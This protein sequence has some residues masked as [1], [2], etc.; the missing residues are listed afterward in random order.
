MNFLQLF[1]SHLIKMLLIMQAIIRFLIFLRS[2]TIEVCQCRCCVYLPTTTFIDQIS[3]LCLMQSN[4]INLIRRYK[5]VRVYIHLNN[6][7]CSNI[8]PLD[9]L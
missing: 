5:I 9:L 8:L 2:E 4:H 7:Y 3:I 1:S 6:D